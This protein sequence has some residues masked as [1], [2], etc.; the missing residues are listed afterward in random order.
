MENKTIE[1][2]YPP[3]VSVSYAEKLEKEIM[4]RPGATQEQK[5]LAQ[6]L[7]T[8]VSLAESFLKK[9]NKNAN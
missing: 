6:D 5:A 4:T 7:H 2:N 8:L 3:S 1:L 9:I